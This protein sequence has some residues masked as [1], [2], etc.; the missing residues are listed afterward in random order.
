MRTSDILSF[1]LPICKN[2][3]WVFLYS[4]DWLLKI[5][6]LSLANRTF[7]VWRG[8]HLMRRRY[9]IRNLHYS[10]RVLSESQIDCLG[11]Q[12]I[13]FFRHPT[14]TMESA[15]LRNR[16]KHLLALDL[17]WSLH[18]TRLLRFPIAQLNLLQPIDIENLSINSG[19]FRFLYVK[20]R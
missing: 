9:K 8:A 5:I 19:K 3:F 13:Y 1:G 10:S 2:S 12:Q 16:A 18:G 11:S 15:S 7:L 17:S 4:E 20:H 14:Q 6:Y